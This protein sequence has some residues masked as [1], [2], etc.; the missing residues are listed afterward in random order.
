MTFEEAL[1]I[2]K[3]VPEHPTQEQLLLIKLAAKIVTGRFGVIS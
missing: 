1:A 3:T 2:L